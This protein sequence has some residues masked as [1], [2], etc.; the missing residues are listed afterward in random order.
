MSDLKLYSRPIVIKPAWSHPPF[1]PLSMWLWPP[2]T[3]KHFLLSLPFYNKCLKT[4]N[5]YL[6][7]QC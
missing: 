5:L 7:P 1:D 3:S 2:S 6:D 4:M